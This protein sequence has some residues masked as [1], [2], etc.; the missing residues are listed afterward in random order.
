MGDAD[1]HEVAKKD[2]VRTALELLEKH[3]PDRG[4]NIIVLAAPTVLGDLRKHYPDQ[5]RAVIAAE[6][7]KDVV[8]HSPEQ[9]V[10]IIESHEN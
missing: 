5:L 9:I 1:W 3:Y 7:D 4:G 2:F 8:N 10:A 6:I